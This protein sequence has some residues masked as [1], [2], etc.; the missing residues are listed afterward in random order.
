[1]SSF[2]INVWVLGWFFRKWDLWYV[3]VGVG[4]LSCMCRS[5]QGWVLIPLEEM[6]I[7]VC[8]NTSFE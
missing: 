1:M 2:Q 8:V 4:L 6:S 3:I 7:I 5:F